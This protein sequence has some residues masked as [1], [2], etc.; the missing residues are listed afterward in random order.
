MNTL[1]AAKGLV[2]IDEVQ[3]RP[4]LY[5][6][7]RVLADRPRKP[8]RFLLLGSASP[9]LVKGVTETLAGRIA[10]VDLGGFDLREVS[11]DRTERLWSRGG[12]PP[13]FLAASSRAS[14]EWRRQYV[15]N[16][17]R[18]DIPQLGI[19]I[20]AAVLERFWTMLAHYHGGIWNGAEFARSLGT[21]EP[22]ARRYLDLLTEAYVARQLQPWY[23]NIGKRQIRSP[24][25]YV[26][27]TGLLHALLMIPDEAGLAANIKRGASWEGFVIEQVLSLLRDTPAFFWATHQGAELDL[28]VIH[29]GHR[30]GFEV[31][32]ADA[33]GFT[34]SMGIAIEDL[35]L[36]R[37]YV[38]HHGTRSWKLQGNAEVVSIRDL[39]ALLRNLK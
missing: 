4:D 10:H 21:S 39:P 19:T 8:A 27:D 9:D 1:R 22:T 25:V 12:L 26:R 5:P 28:M 17:L 11:T 16:F 32:L 3:R 34:R 29:R 13:S 31:K 37:L 6:I 36:S 2:V 15:L 14:F 7:L 23:E 24:K 20:P 30:I 18:R 38:V 33:P 35:K